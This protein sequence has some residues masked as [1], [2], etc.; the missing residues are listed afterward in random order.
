VQPRELSHAVFQEVVV[1]PAT[2]VGE[3]Q[4]KKAAR[5]LAQQ[6]LYLQCPPSHAGRIMVSTLA[7]N[8]PEQAE[9]FWITALTILVTFR[10]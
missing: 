3:K 4:N 1:Q 7:A 9:P 8:G 5:R 6:Q 10:F 2:D